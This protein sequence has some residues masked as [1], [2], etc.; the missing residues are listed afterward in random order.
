MEVFIVSIFLLLSSCTPKI[1]PLEAPVPQPEEFTSQGPVAL[2]DEWWASFDDPILD[3]LVQVGLEE[4]LVLAGNWQQYKAARAIVRRER[5]FLFPEV[6]AFAGVARNQPQGNF[7]EDL[8]FQTGL[9]ASYE[10]DVWGRIR[11]GIQA[12]KYTAEAILRDYQAAA[13]TVSAEISNTWYELLTAH[14]QLELI[15]QQIE[16][17]EAIVK[18][19]RA[20]FAGGQIR[21]VD[22]LRQEQLLESTRD[23]KIFY[24]TNLEL[25]ENRLAV[26]LGRPPQNVEDFRTGIIPN[27]PPLPQTGLPLELIRRRPDLQQAYNLVLAADREM[28][29]AIRS[30][31]PIISLEATGR[32]NSAEMGNLFENWTYSLAGNLIAP[33]IY[34]GRLSA[35]VDRT[36]AVKNQRLFEYGQAVLIAFEEVEN[37]L[38]QEMK[39]IERLEVLERR[40]DLSSKTAKQLRIEFLNGLSPYLDVLLALDEQQQLEREMLE[41]RQELLEI[42]IGLYRALAGAF[43]TEREARL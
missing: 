1:A 31:F 33:I 19:I 7:S 2:S 3:S 8:Q 16:T 42:R 28:A 5:S 35:E 34:G 30:K 4:N 9:A 15:E 26:L 40:L 18:L 32:F 27:L 20:R 25:L 24:E 17:N 41:A 14:K 37:A 12:E 22:I 43:E 29:F 38:F 23:L 36:E 13:M 21:A 6:D 10:L 11:A 39:Q